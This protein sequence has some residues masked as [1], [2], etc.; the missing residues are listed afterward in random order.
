[1]SALGLT[2]RGYPFQCRLSDLLCEAVCGKDGG[3]M[4]DEFIEDLCAILKANGGGMATPGWVAGQPE[5]EQLRDFPIR[6]IRQAAGD[7]SRS[8]GL[9]LS[10]LLRRCREIDHAQSV[11]GLPASASRAQVRAMQIVESRFTGAAGT[12]MYGIEP[13]VLAQAHA[14]L[15]ERASGSLSQEDRLRRRVPRWRTPP[16]AALKGAPVIAADDVEVAIVAILSATSGNWQFSSTP[17]GDVFTH[18]LR[19]YSRESDREYLSGLSDV[20]DTTADLIES[21]RG[22]LGGRVYVTSRYVECAECQ[23]VMA[24]LNDTGSGRSTVFGRCSSR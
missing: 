16:S 10:S 8:G 19:G 12:A 13:E 5:A 20:L 2:F 21:H 4:D 22:G 23:R 17:H 1:M 14:R 15:R 18:Q 11:L 9:N 3:G 24:W 7:A 6:V